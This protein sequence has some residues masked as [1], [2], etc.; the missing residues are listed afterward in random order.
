MEQVTA[1]KARPIYD[2]AAYKIPFIYTLGELYRYRHLV[3]HLISR[4]LKV[5]YKRSFFGF[6]WVMLNPLLLMGSLAFAFSSLFGAQHIEVYI[7][8]GVLLWN[9]FS[10][11]TIAAM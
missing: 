11:G 3:G 4:D 10:Q 6:V 9:T 1:Q 5:R 8:S 7:L 2:S